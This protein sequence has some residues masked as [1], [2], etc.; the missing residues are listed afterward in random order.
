MEKRLSQKIEEFM[1]S[2]KASIVQEVTCSN[3]EENEKLAI[4]KFING[5]DN[6]CV[7]KSDFQKRKRSQNTV[8]PFLRC[9]S[10][11]S[12]GEQCSR[13]KKEGCDF[14]GT[15]SKGSPHG[16]FVQDNVIMKKVE[17]WAQEI[18]GIIY[19]IDNEMNVYKTEDIINNK[20]NPSIVAK[21]QK[22]GEI[23]S[24]LDFEL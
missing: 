23:Y 2:M 24:I 21:Y 13:R 7:E 18:G 19:Y 9:L 17:V 11:R 5:Y 12:D 15:H 3:V 4:C 6:F 1:A 16:N 8:A 22:N 20:T 14:C 10:K